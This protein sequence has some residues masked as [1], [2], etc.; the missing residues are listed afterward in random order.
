MYGVELMII[1]F[2]TLGLSIS[3]NGS[4][5]SIISVTIFWRICLGIGIGGDYPSSSVIMSE[6]ANVKWRGAMMASVVAHQGFGQFTAALVAFICAAGFKD[7]LQSVQCN[8]DCQDALDK[9]WRILYGLGILPALVA[10]FFRFT[11][12][13]S[14]R[15]TLDVQRNEAIA[16]ANALNYINRANNPEDLSTR[17]TAWILR[18]AEV[19]APPRA[20]VRDFLNHF[21]TWRNGKVLLGT[22]SS[23]FF[24]DIAFVRTPYRKK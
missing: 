17:V 10:L 13:E 15:Y 11:I 16:R 6:F 22:A 9:S 23:W 12:P 19:Q 18:Q 3:A 24:L 4:T 2:A 5:V 7:S 8:Q 21:G 14:I 20:S 1:I